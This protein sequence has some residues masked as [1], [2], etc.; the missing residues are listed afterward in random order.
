MVHY[1]H[2]YMY[3]T[4]HRYP[5]CKLQMSLPCTALWII[6]ASWESYSMHSIPSRVNV[7][8][9]SVT[10]NHGGD[11]MFGAPPF[12]FGKQPKPLYR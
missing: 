8:I 11:Q 3:I 4:V 1:H 9:L 6:V 2:K 10:V 5:T 7:W 12:Q